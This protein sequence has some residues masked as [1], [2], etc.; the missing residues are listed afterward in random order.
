MQAEFRREGASVGRRPDLVEGKS[1]QK[2]RP[3]GRRRRGGQITGSTPG[4]SPSGCHKVNSSVPSVSLWF[5]HTLCWVSAGGGPRFLWTLIPRATAMSPTSE[6][7]SKS[8][9]RASVRFLPFAR[10]C[11]PGQNLGSLA[12][13]PS[14]STAPD[15]LTRCGISQASHLQSPRLPRFAPKEPI[16]LQSDSCPL[17]GLAH[18]GKTS[19]VWPQ[20][21][22]QQPYPIP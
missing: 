18:P 7:C 6:V 5:N 3:S 21:T 9:D 19:E 15:P 20:R 1:R 2:P 16:G 22:R 17:P 14:A 10:T 8:T 4:E 11:T 12:S 13:T